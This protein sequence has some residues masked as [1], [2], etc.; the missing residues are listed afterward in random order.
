MGLETHLCTN[1]HQCDNWQLVRFQGAVWRSV[2]RRDYFLFWYQI[3]MLTDAFA[4]KKKKEIIS[5]RMANI[6]YII[7]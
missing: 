3:T 5:E 1:L 2:W 4:S 6:E 7:Q